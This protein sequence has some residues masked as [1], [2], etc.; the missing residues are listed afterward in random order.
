MTAPHRDPGLQE[1]WPSRLAV[2][3]WSVLGCSAAGTMRSTGRPGSVIEETLGKK[4]TSK[5]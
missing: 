2:I 4:Y 1:A 5:K 3:R